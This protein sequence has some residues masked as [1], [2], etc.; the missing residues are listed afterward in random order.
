VEDA[1]RRFYDAFRRAD[2]KV[3]C[4]NAGIIPCVHCSLHASTLRAWLW[5]QAMNDVWGQGQHVQCI[6]PAAGC[7]A[8]RDNVRSPSHQNGVI[9]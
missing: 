9:L 6:H 2:L 7:I 1:N 5:R 8:G 4:F 3:R